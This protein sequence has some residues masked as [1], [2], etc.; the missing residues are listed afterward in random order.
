MADATSKLSLKFENLSKTRQEEIKQRSSN[1]LGQTGF[2]SF[3]GKLT[4]D[5]FGAK[6]GAGGDIGGNVDVQKAVS[7]LQALGASEKQISDILESSKKIVTENRYVS[8]GLGAATKV[9]VEIDE[10]QASDVLK[11]LEE[12]LSTGLGKTLDNQFKTFETALSRIDLNLPSG[13]GAAQ[14]AAAQAYG[15]KRFADLTPEQKR[16]V[17]DKIKS[18]VEITKEKKKQQEADNALNFGSRLALSLAQKQV[19]TTIELNKLSLDRL[20][21][22]EQSLNFKL[23]TL[24]LSEREKIIN[25]S[26]LKDLE[27]ER[28]ARK[29]LVDLGKEALDDLAKSATLSVDPQNL[30][31]LNKSLTN[32]NFGDQKQLDDLASKIATTYGIGTQQVQARLNAI[33]AEKSEQDKLL[34]A[35][36]EKNAEETNFQLRVESATTALKNQ[37]SEIERIS[38]AIQ[39][40]SDLNI[41]FKNLD[42]AKTEGEITRLEALLSDPNLSKAQ[43]D[44]INKQVIGLKQLNNERRIGVEQENFAAKAQANSLELVKKQEKLQELFKLEPDLSLIHI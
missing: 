39:S 27:A 28:E 37:R 44:S 10:T 25:E 9:S 6:K 4:S 34:K 40:I 19:D 11:K 42:I 20:T 13:R 29:K 35:G 7:Q 31:D 41:S 24:D 30:K 16:L 2:Q 1:L 23:Q 14:E 32:I 18:E 15:Q 21:P 36:K 43:Q 17:E 3:F 33:K 22:E 8:A 26:R 38:S 5:I 12:E